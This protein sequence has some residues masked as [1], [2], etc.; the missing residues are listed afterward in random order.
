[1]VGFAAQLCIDSTGASNMVLPIIL[2]DSGD[3]LI[4]E[5]IDEA[6]RYIEPID[7][8]NNVYR[9][10]DSQGRLLRLATVYPYKTISISLAEEYPHH[11]DDLVQELK[12]FLSFMGVS[13]E[14]IEN[15]SLEELVMEALKY[16]TG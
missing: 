5:S 16:K 1:M 8:K 12:Y 2:S 7:V 14:W 4:F 11:K 10:F 3:L 9:G 6:L 15:A 13:R